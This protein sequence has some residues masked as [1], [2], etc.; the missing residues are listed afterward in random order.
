MID[1]QPLIRVRDAEGKFIAWETIKPLPVYTNCQTSRYVEALYDYLFRVGA[2]Y[3]SDNFT[4]KKA[5]LPTQT[6]TKV[7][8]L[9][10][11]ILN[12]ATGHGVDGEYNKNGRFVSMFYA[13][14]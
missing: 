3:S 5:I 9:Q 12:D 10:S 8:S 14:L 7:A 6:K 4:P 13:A 2:V 11:Y 1:I